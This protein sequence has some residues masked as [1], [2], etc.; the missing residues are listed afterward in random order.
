MRKAHKTLLGISI[1]A[2]CLAS[3]I[4]IT[5]LAHHLYKT[6][7]PWISISCMCMAVFCVLLCNDPNHDESFGNPFGDEN[8]HNDLMIISWFLFGTLFTSAFAVI[9]F[10]IHNELAPYEISYFVNA[11]NILVGSVLLI[12][13]K[14]ASLN[15]GSLLY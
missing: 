3:A 12:V 2:F 13:Y 11:S 5:A 8:L 9:P 1:L 6:W 4:F 14:L 10:M 7:I 15:G